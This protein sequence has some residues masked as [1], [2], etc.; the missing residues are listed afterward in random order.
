MPRNRLNIALIYNAL[1]PAA[2]EP[3][4]DM[5]STAELRRMIRHMARAIKSRG[6]RVTVLPLEQDLFS[7]HRRLRKLNPDV[8]FNQYDD[9]V[10]GALY[11]MRAAALISMLGYPMT[12]SP[13]LA[14][15]L[16]RYKFICASLLQG[17]GVP[18]PEDTELIDRVSTVN[19]RSW[20][21]PLIV[22]PCRED[23]GIG[24]DRQSVVYTKKA[25][26]EKV[27]WVLKEFKQPA[28]VQRFLPGREFNVGIIGGRR[29]RVLPL[30]EV[31]YSGLPPDIPPIMSYA[32]KWLENTPENKNTKIVCPAEVEP[33]LARKISRTALLAFQAV[34]GWGY[35]RVDMRLD[36][37]NIPRVL[38]VNCNA[39]L[40]DGIGLA[41]QARVAGIEY[42]QLL[43][44]IIDA[45][46][47]RPPF[48]VVLPMK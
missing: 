21:F 25:M 28:L 7:F 5:G 31:D 35:G 29:L 30:A 14:I 19:G 6:H 44:H 8:V 43:Q 24:L 27:R 15:G 46:L 13:P 48:D 39:S 22:Q 33:E 3:S 16:A 42:P 9:V 1:V 20:N 40:E 26:R 4:E 2:T 47:E 11:E 23:A 36:Q 18:I 45:A 17:V 38:E 41:R 12:G 10:H 37:N 32:A 34:G